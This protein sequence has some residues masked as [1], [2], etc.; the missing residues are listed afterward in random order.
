MIETFTW[1]PRVNPTEDITYKIRRAKFGDGYEQVSGDGINARSQKW[2]LEFT[3]RG[4]YITAIRQFID[5]HGGIKAFQWKP[6]L[7]PVGLY[8]CADHKLTPLGGD[9]YSLSLTFTQAFKP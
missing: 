6:P 4:E 1:C 8:R 3:G 2:S 5:L 9:N 7:E